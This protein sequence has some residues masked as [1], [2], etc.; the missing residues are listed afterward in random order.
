MHGLTRM[1]AND[2]WARA[3]GVASSHRAARVPSSPWDVDRDAYGRIEAC[4][5]GTVRLARIRA[6]P[7]CIEQP[8]E[9]VANERAERY[10]VLV[11]V[12]GRS[13]LNQSGREVVLQSGDWSIYRSGVPFTLWNV[14]RS[15]QR[16]VILPRAEL[17]GRTLELE[18]LTVRRFNPS[19]HSGQLANLLD[20]AFETAALFGD[21]AASELAGAAVHLA[22]LVL[23]EGAGLGLRSVRADVMQSRIRSYVDRNLHDPALSVPGIA[24]ALNCST[25][26]LHKVFSD[27]DQTLAEYILNQRLQRCFAELTYSGPARRS[28]AELAYAGGFKSLSHFSKA[29]TRRFR[30]TPGEQ[31]RRAASSISGPSPSPPC[32]R[33]R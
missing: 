1:G 23:M 4:D 15:E 5:I 25:R 8:G 14:E 3:G 17:W 12:S 27:G 9:A 18:A 30:V 29:F 16:M 7:L 10:R 13:V 2:A 6:N 21:V 11:Q 24:A 22:R 26:Y 32:R 19:A 33:S 31:R 20:S 28:I